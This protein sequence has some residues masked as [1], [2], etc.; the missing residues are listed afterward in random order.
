M[1]VKVGLGVRVV[2]AVKVGVME[3][4]KVGIATSISMLPNHDGT[5]EFS[6]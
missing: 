5:R 6:T 1:G 4:V 2:V 3:G